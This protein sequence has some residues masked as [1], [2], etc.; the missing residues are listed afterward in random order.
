MDEI[1]TVLGAVS[2]FVLGAA[3]QPWV[4]GLVFLGCLIDGFFPPFPSESIV[5]GLAALVVVQD[6]PDLWLL[7]LA[8]ALGAFAGDNIAYDL[9]RR[10]GAGRARWLSGPRMQRSLARVG[11]DL[12]HRGASL[13]LAARFVPIGRV[14]VN[15]TAGATLYAR[16]RFVP[17]AALSG[18]A[19]A[20]YTVGI[21]AL[22]GTWFRENQ[23]LGMAAALV[24]AA[25]IG[26]IVDRVSGYRRRRNI[27]ATAA[28]TSRPVPVRAKV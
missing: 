25:V 22:A 21:G 7:I 19:W 16:K 23:L 24:L 28:A 26:L 10:A 14:A 15:L 27:A 8:A 13:I 1:N 6:G 4:Y 2:D 20:V 18:L 11:R 17:V 5:V 9:G 12:D 3:G